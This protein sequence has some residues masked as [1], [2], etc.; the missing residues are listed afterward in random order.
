MAAV[1]YGAASLGLSPPVV[2]PAPQVSVVWPA[3]GVA[4]AAVALFGLRIWPAIAL[5]AFIANWHRSPVAVATG[6]AV[7][8][9]LEA[10]VGGW[11]LRRMNFQVGLNR[12][13][14]ALGLIGLA[15][16]AA[17]AVSATIGVTTLC[18]SGIY[19]WQF[20]R[21]L[22]VF[23][24]MGDAVGVIVVAPALLL[25]AARP[26]IHWDRKRIA[27]AAAV[28]AAVVAIGLAVFLPRYRLV[29]DFPFV[30]AIF[31]AVIWA[32]LRFGPPGAVLATLV[33]TSI[34]LAGTLLE[35]G[36][37]AIAMGHDSL[38]LLQSFVGTVAASGLLIASA[39]A[40]RQQALEAMLSL[41][42]TLEVRVADRSAELERRAGQLRALAAQLSQVEQRERRRLAT[43]LHDQLQQTLIAANLH[44]DQLRRKPLS[45]E[46]QAGLGA[47]GELLQQAIGASRSLAVELSPPV[48][49]EAGLVPALRWLARQV[50]TQYGL[51]VEV[52]AEEAQPVLDD[53]VATFVFQAVRELLLNVIQHG[54]TEKASI[55]VS[56]APANRLRVS[57]TDR[58]LG[59]DPALTASG[60]P[61]RFG[62]LSIRERLEQLGGEFALEAAPRQGV[63]VTLNVPLP[64]ETADLL[65]GL[66][67]PRAAVEG[68]ALSVGRPQ[69]DGI[70]VMLVDDHRIVREGLRLLLENQTG[71][72]I[73]GEAADGEE[74]LDVLSRV[75]PDVV[76]MDVNMPRMNGVECTR[77]IKRERPDVA[78]IALSFHQEQDIAESMRE[79]GAE[80]YVRKDG[81]PD[82]L[83]R[84]IRAVRTA[85]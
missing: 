81:P 56:A 20:Y 77:R 80:S 76:L 26:R 1:Y 25:L 39:T 72:E 4:I 43:L 34:G 23:W 57:V 82:E 36:P 59:F 17:T 9:T 15:A 60:R 7:G 83:C 53:D 61:D 22:W 73:V 54:G 64:D 13:R 42:Q 51:Q 50:E 62:L 67:T 55:A 52:E 3:S 32:A 85:G 47:I 8:N 10:V 84:A 65:A 40:E 75:E 30:Y 29:S 49:H 63:R 45:G 71:I 69:A 19:G 12:L 27:E 24:W 6:I 35:R 33:S 5:G 38:V 28:A 16:V 11:L 21:H 78:V 70:R 74:A 48:L 68:T 66:P 41:N 14:D 46:T 18:A 44:V 58:G 79:A 2:S 37:F 31:L